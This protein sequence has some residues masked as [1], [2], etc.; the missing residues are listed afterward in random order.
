MVKIFSS[1]L[2][3][4][5]RSAVHCTSVP[6]KI[7]GQLILPTL[8]IYITAR[9]SAP[10]D[11]RGAD[12]FQSLI[13]SN[14]ASRSPGE[15]SGLCSCRPCA[16]RVI[17]SGY[18][19]LPIWNVSEARKEKIIWVFSACG[20]V[21]QV[22]IVVFPVIY[23]YIWETNV[24]VALTVIYQTRG[25]IISSA[26]FGIVRVLL[27]DEWRASGSCARQQKERGG[28]GYVRI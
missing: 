26:R 28:E 11:G 10:M 20:N 23:I 21:L 7:F 25:G 9:W 5:R 24:R 17:Y 2:S 8:S 14:C 22:Y 6:R 3:L 19:A 13:G 18:I 15:I 4:R 27:L 16:T 12:E 1:S